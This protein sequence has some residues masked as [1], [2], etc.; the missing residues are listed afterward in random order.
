MGTLVSVMAGVNLGGK[1]TVG[2]EVT[3]ES[4]DIILKPLLH[5]IAMCSAAE[6]LEKQTNS[7]RAGIPSASPSSSP[8][9]SASRSKRQQQCSLLSV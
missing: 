6:H 4:K 2:I 9:T 8:L 7:I 5:R 1:Q 3:E